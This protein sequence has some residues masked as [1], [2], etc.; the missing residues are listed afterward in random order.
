MSIFKS[1]FS[2]TISSQLKAR[3]KVISTT[4]PRDNTFLQYTSGKNSWV[5]M[6][7]FV[8]Y[9]DPKGR[10]S[11]DQLSR[12]YILEGGTL[13]N[14][15]GNKGTLR[16]GVNKVDGVY[17]GDLDKISADPS[18]NKVDRLFGIRPMPG[19]TSVNIINKSAYGSLREATVQFYC[20][21]KH[22]LEELEILFMRTGYT[23]FLEWGWSQYIDHEIAEVNKY[24]DTT[25]IKTFD[26]ITLDPFSSG[27]NDNTIYNRIDNDIN[28][29]KG[30]YDA[31]LGYVQNFSWQLMPNGGFQCSTTLI[32][33]GEV[34]SGI[35]VSSNNNVILGSNIKSPT[36]AVSNSEE[37]KPILS[38]FEKIFSN[39][40]GHVNESE[41]IKSLVT[42][43]ITTGGSFFI[44]GSNTDQ[45]Q[46][47]RDQADE[48]YN[49]INKKLDSSKYKSVE[50]EWNDY[51]IDF[52]TDVINLD[53]HVF[54]KF[55]D[56]QT[57]GTAIEYIS[58]DAF[59]T[60]LNEFFIIKDKNTNKPAIFVVIPK[61]TPCLASEDSVSIDPT[62]CL[63]KNSQAKFIT[64]N[65]DGFNP[66][67]YKNI[68][69]KSLSGNSSNSSTSLSDF[70]ASGTTN[71]GYI[72]NVYVSINKLIQIYRKLYNGPD[73]VNILDYLQEVL[74]TISFSLGSINDFKLYSEKNTVQIID[75]K[76]FETGADSKVS[77]KFKF[78]LFGL[79]SICRNVKINSRIFSE[80]STMIGIGATSGN[81]TNLGDVYTSTQNYF[82]RDLKDRVLTTTFDNNE[83]EKIGNITLN[84]E[85]LYRYNTYQNIEQLTSYIN[86][87]VLGIL[88][89]NFN[90]KI[91]RLP[92]ENDVINAGSLLKTYHYQINGKDIDFKALIPFELEMTLDGISGFII[93]QIFVIDKSIL[94]KDYQ[95]KNLG[96]II[97][98]VNHSLQNNDWITT[99]K[100]QVCLL[101]NDQI[102]DKYKK[103]YG[104]DKS[105]LKQLITETRI[106]AT[107]SGFLLLALSDYLTHL[108]IEAFCEID[109]GKRT[110][111]FNE[112]FTTLTNVQLIKN[113]VNAD[114]I[115]ALYY[116]T[117]INSTPNKINTYLKNWWNYVNRKNINNFP[118]FSE[119]IK[120]FNVNAF[121]NFILKPDEESKFARNQVKR[122]FDAL[123]VRDK[124]AFKPFYKKAWE[125]TF[126]YEIL[127]TN[128][129]LPLPLSSVKTRSKQYPINISQISAD[130]TNNNNLNINKY[131][132]PV[133]QGFSLGDGTDVKYPASNSL[134]G[135]TAL[136]CTYLKSSPITSIYAPPNGFKPDTYEN[137]K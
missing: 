63:I 43:N 75:A 70:I 108:T 130:I 1:T 57:E 69:V 87:N 44:E 13:Y 14:A 104:I 117:N 97:T 81:I 109:G 49:D 79:K 34:I 71:V 107:K 42:G 29:S 53:D 135:V 50:G 59:I 7:S 106:E 24:P 124:E 15:G 112:Y 134:T 61:K 6:T 19:I 96:F 105:L 9:K 80:Q 91:T 8:N 67:V 35:K 77:S 16:S 40:I 37:P 136:Y 99:I 45:Q 62:A 33:R 12:K 111:E 98:G 78:D 94:P 115:D 123:T 120:D 27:L 92:Q 39:I 10:Y 76:Y 72:G 95:N 122:A 93:G 129:E 4:N 60:I 65:E 88:E 133:N 102:F 22:Q 103:E 31:V 131:I 48:I 86:R 85:E 128:G 110:N 20:W 55:C 125:S 121:Q 54:V 100:T 126:F 18:D 11:G 116:Y 58:M 90:I 127:K 23:V 68:D 32:S 83:S 56:G 73:G 47:L 118:T 51:K 74:D 25:K 52:S 3:E 132:I 36:T 82:N 26:I 114:N 2:K 28:K 137:V 38:L 101:E 21:D 46:A 119:F 66:N 84:P 89:K 5:R 113:M 64:N 17:G 41:F 30:N